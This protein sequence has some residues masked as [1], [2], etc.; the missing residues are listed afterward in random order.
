M[1]GAAPA[2]LRGRAFE[3]DHFVAWIRLKN[4]DRMAPG[5]FRPLRQPSVERDA[6]GSF[7][8]NFIC[9]SA[10]DSCW[11]RE[12]LDAGAFLSTRFLV[13]YAKVR[14]MAVSETAR[15]PPRGARR[16]NPVARPTFVR[17]KND[18]S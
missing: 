2:Y 12:L 5:F 13:A 3:L 6:V 14:I 10:T 16:H 4:F 1:S 8:L 17:E 18:H 7:A 15:M 11:S 9:V